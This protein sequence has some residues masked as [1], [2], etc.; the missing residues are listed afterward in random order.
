MNRTKVHLPSDV[1]NKKHLFTKREKEHVD[2]F[3]RGL[4]IPQISAKLDIKP[5]TVETHLHNIK[6]K[7][8]TNLPIIKK[9]NNIDANND[10]YATIGKRYS[11]T[12]IGNIIH[13]KGL[14]SIKFLCLPYLGT[15]LVIINNMVGVDTYNI[16]AFEAKNS[17]YTI[18]ENSIKS[19]LSKDVKLINQNVDSFLKKCSRID[20]DVAHLDYN[21][22][23][24]HQRISSVKHLVN[25]SDCKLIFITI[26]S[27]SRNSK[28]QDRNVGEFP[29]IKGVNCTFQWQYRGVQNHMMETFCLERE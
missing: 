8:R 24:T 25:K 28:I 23:L 26:Q 1:S 5:R 22:P 27:D 21:G 10:K 29:K 18:C 13:S 7:V 16:L 9:K 15:E 6:T 2:L 3:M 19:K 11:I 4:S 12:S 17:I 14:R 20:I